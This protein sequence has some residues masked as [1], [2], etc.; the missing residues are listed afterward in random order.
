MCIIT[1]IVIKNPIPNIDNCNIL[2]EKLKINFTSEEHILF[3]Q[4]FYICYSNTTDEHVVDVEDILNWVGFSRKEK[5]KNLLIKHYIFNKD[6]ILNKIDKDKAIGGSGINKEIIL[7]TTNCFKTICLTAKTEKSKEIRLYNNIL[8]NVL[9]ETISEQSLKLGD[10]LVSKNKEF[11]NILVNKFENQHIVYLIYVE[12]DI[13]K[14]GFTKN[15]F[16]R[17]DDHRKQFGN[18]IILFQVFQTLYNIELEAQIKADS[19]IS[20]YIFSKKYKKNQTEL[21]RVSNQFTQKQLEDRIEYLKSTINPIE[22]LI[23]ENE[24]LKHELEKLKLECQSQ[25]QILKIEKLESQLE[26]EKLRVK[27]I[28]YNINE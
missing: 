17:M 24:N 12:T 2:V 27:L 26:C 14:F 18:N 4:K 5:V 8:E 6:Y 7:M 15:I 11:E 28:K 1:D 22:N 21:I 19:Y 16:K 25:C 10:Q 20:Q 13:I 3:L 23:R 9:S